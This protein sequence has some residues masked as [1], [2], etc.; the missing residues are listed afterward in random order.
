VTHPGVRA[1]GFA[2]NILVIHLFGDAISPPVIGYL[3]GRFGDEIGFYLIAFVVLLGGVFWICGSV[4]LE[5][6]T[7]LAGTRG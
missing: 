7:R 4:F 5:R 2:L 3:S 6:D 1:S